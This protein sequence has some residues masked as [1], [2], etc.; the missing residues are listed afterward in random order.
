[1]SAI[2]RGRSPGHTGQSRGH[3]RGHGHGSSYSSEAED[4]AGVVMD[5]SRLS[6]SNASPS[7]TL[8]GQGGDTSSHGNSIWYD[9]LDSS[10]SSLVPE[11]KQKALEMLQAKLSK[12]KEQIKHE[13]SS[14]D[15]NVEE[16]LRYLQIQI[17]YTH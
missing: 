7:H 17:F 2:S 9:E 5:T 16:Y 6:S 10:T 3:S 8:S 1:M 15:S 13:Q 12:T 14:R 11:R 4:G